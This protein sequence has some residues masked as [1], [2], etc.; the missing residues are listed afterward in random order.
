M[1]GEVA[2][3]KF[4]LASIRQLADGGIR[5]SAKRQTVHSFIKNSNENV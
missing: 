3:L 2:N 5:H 4:Y 1:A